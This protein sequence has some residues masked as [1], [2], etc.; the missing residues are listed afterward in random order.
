MDAKLTTAAQFRPVA[1]H[2]LLVIFA[3]Q[4][5]DA[6]NQA[7]IALDHAIAAAGVH[8]VRE[9]VPA[10]V[11]LL[12]DFDPVATDHAAVEAAVRGLLAGLRPVDAEGATRVVQV[13]YEAEFAP[14][15]PA[16]AAA[17][18]LSE[19]AVIN[20]HLAGDYRVLMYGFAPGYAYMAG[21]P[22]P[23]QTPRKPSPV[24][25]IPG[26]S[27]LIAGPQCLVTTMMM[28]TGWSIIG[29]SPTQVLFDDAA[30]P[31]LFDVGDRVAFQRID[32]AAFERLSKGGGDG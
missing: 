5:S 28:P 9:V 26:G 29:R 32:R 7:V 31:S 10:I 16:V 15:L 17:R 21:V 19:E 24:R 8:G 3:D 25:D 11:N 2:A 14:D 23:I 12:I 22:E 13:C 20:A 1:D 30:R 27:V 18:G 6:A 4:I